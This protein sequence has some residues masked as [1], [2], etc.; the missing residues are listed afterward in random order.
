MGS[1]RFVDGTH[2]EVRAD[3]R[4]LGAG[5]LQADDVRDHGGAQLGLSARTWEAIAPWLSVA[6]SVKVCVTNENGAPMVEHVNTPLVA[7]MLHRPGWSAA[8]KAIL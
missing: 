8:V 1:G 7:P 4:A 5:L 2:L 3:D 6:K